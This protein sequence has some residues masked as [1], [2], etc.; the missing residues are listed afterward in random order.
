MPASKLVV[1]NEHYNEDM[2]VMEAPDKSTHRLRVMRIPNDLD[3][4]VR[5]LAADEE[6]SMTS[7]WVRLVREAVKARG[8][9]QVTVD[10]GEPF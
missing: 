3:G 8:V 9:A 1:S 2:T 7:M 6:R 10:D 4:Q 5:R